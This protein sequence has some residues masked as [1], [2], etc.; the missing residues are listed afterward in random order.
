MTGQELKELRLELGVPRRALANMVHVSDNVIQ[1]V[2]KGLPIR[3]DNA[4]ELMEQALIDY[5]REVESRHK[6]K[7]VEAEKPVKI[8]TLADENARAK[9][10]GIS[11]GT[12]MAY[13]ETG[14]LETFIKS[15][16]TEAEKDIGAN[17]VVST[18]GAATSSFPRYCKYDENRFQDCSRNI[19][20]NHLN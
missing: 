19:S 1:H 9:E 13:K 11:Y 8:A 3:I 2:E 16:K 6:A 17:I 15:Q 4:P 20:D 5:K 18:I 12:Y 10:L 14:Y 7:H